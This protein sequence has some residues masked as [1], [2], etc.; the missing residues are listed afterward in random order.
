MSFKVGIIGHTGRGNYGHYLDLAF[1]GVEGADIAALADPDDE[2]RAAAAARTG[3]R[4]VYADYREMLERE[5]PDVAVVASREVGD[6]RELVIAAAQAGANVYL[7]KPVAAAPQD[8]DAMHAACRQAGVQCVV[9][10]PWRGHPPIQRTAI[11]LIQSGR[12]GQPRLAR[13]FCK[14]GPHGGNQMFLDL[15]P[16]FVDFLWQLFGAPLWCQA[17]LTQ[18]GRSCQPSDLA[19]GWE[20]MGLVAGNGLKAYYCFEDGAAADFEAY[21][22]DGASDPYGVEIL[23]TEGALWLPGPMGRGPDIYWNPSAA[24]TPLRGDRWEVVPSDPPPHGAK[25]LDA[26]RRMARAL[27]DVLEG[28]PPAWELVHLPDARRFLETALLAHAAHVQGARVS[29]PLPDGKNPFDHWSA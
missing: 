26:H 1:V 24:P 7:E 25:W 23:G 29:P 21:Q 6:H 2:G 17:H 13:V 15:Y 28:K 9:A 4:A 12:I 18:N 22:G 5:R 14:D 8:V 16:H 19:P 3:A 11:P 27:L 20:G 10:H